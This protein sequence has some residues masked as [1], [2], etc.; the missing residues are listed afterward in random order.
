MN[1]QYYI[2]KLLDTIKDAYVK[3]EFSSSENEYDQR[4]SEFYL[5]L[6]ER[7]YA[8]QQKLSQ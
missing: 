1:K 8:I 5:T 3:H 2:R 7:Y 4:G 6:W